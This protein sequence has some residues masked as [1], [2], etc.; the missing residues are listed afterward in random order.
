MEQS[1]GSVDRRRVPTGLKQHEL[2]AAE[3]LAARGHCIGSDPHTGEG[4]TADFTIDGEIWELK[5][6]LGAS[7]DAIARN[8]RAAAKQAKRAVL[9]VTNS[10]VGDERIKVLAQQYSRRYKLASV[11][12]FR[13]TDGMD[14]RFDND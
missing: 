1:R 9:D 14:W 12:V 13:E 11:R 4:K 7:E 2:D 8:I 6:I 5:S 3:R 10:A